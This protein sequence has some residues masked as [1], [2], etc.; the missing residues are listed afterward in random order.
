MDN[1]FTAINNSIRSLTAL[2]P[3]MAPASETAFAPIW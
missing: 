3:G 1:L 2:L